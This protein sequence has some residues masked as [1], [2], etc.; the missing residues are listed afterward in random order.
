M[1]IFTEIT[2]IVAIA[3]FI[4]LIMRLLRQPLVVGYILTGII[5][6]PYTLNILQST[7]QV[8]LFSKIG[9][10]VLLFI[11]GLNLNP[12]VIKELG[13]V[14]LVTGVGQ[15]LVT[16]AIGFSIALLLGIERIAA[17]YLSIALPIASGV[18]KIN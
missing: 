9:I 3:A 8:E 14:S 4:S 15:V 1:N 10:T 12:Q 6:G 13:K 7:D 11:V 5:V 18:D 17:I 2:I 16:S